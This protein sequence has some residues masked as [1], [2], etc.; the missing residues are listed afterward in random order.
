MKREVSWCGLL[1]ALSSPSCASTPETAVRSAPAATPMPEALAVSARNAGPLEETH[2][3]K[4]RLSSS[5]QEMLRVS[6]RLEREGSPD[7]RARW[8][9]ELSAIDHDCTELTGRWQNAQLLPPED[10]VAMEARL[11]PMI[12]VLYAV[13]ARTAA[14]IDQS[15][16]AAAL[17]R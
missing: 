15:L 13:S 5:R 4:E 7:E 6:A 12:D 16:D 17:A 14:Q 3:A 2:F 11:T 1:L 9:E 8:Q 10:R